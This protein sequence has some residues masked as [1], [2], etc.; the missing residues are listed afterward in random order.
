VNKYIFIQARM[1]STRLP[2]KVLLPFKGSTVL[3]F[4]Y[5]KCRGLRGVEKVVILTSTMPDDDAIE[6]ICLANAMPVF[7]GSLYDVLR[8]FQEAA[9]AYCNAN[10]FVIRLCA[11]SPLIEASLLQNFS[12]NI[13]STDYFFS[14]R[15][16][17]N[18]TYISTT[19]KGNN[20]DAVK[21][22]ELEKL[23]SDSDLVREHIV[24]GFD[25]GSKFRLYDSKQIFSENNCIDTLEDYKRLL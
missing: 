19:G 15:Y 1:S 7:R 21:V 2:G 18:G 23:S 3:E 9:K 8:R 13:T 14:T 20:I 6:D 16:L 5:G 24:Y 25:Y 12:D 10:D 22:S 11:D 17:R 4:L